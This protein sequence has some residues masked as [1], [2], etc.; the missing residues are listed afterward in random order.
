MAQGFCQT[1]LRASAHGC[2][3]PACPRLRWELTLHPQP[4]VLLSAKTPS[5]ILPPRQLLESRGHS[6]SFW[7]QLVLHLAPRGESWEV[8]LP[9]REPW[10]APLFAL[11]WI[12]QL[13][14]DQLCIGGVWPPWAAG[15]W[16]S[17]SQRKGDARVFQPSACARQ[18]PALRPW[19]SPIGGSNT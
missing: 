9:A 17:Y 18:C 3:A 2:P 15:H 5:P 7:A 13:S 10:E 14:P 4:H 16:R 6:T 19:L 12:L 1:H 11:R 8:P